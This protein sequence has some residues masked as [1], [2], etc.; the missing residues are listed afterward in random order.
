M[1]WLCPVVPHGYALELNLPGSLLHRQ[2]ELEC[3]DVVRLIRDKELRVVRRCSHQSAAV[4]SLKCLLDKTTGSQGL[5]TL[6]ALQV[7]WLLVCRRWPQVKSMTSPEA[8]HFLALGCRRVM[9]WLFDV[10]ESCHGG[11]E[12]AWQPRA[13]KCGMK[14]RPAD[15]RRKRDLRAE[16]NNKK[17]RNKRS[18]QTPSFVGNFKS[19]CFL[20]KLWDR[21]VSAVAEPQIKWEVRTGRFAYPFAGVKME[22][23]KE[24]IVVPLYMRIFLFAQNLILFQ[25]TWHCI[26]HCVW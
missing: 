12:L 5:I 26:Q 13:R 6:L 20:P 19:D 16:S 11:A 9:G 21:I 4:P 10:D 15:Q 24:T 23:S 7:Y 17:E 3:V 14:S 25:V 18:P 2:V 1:H 22:V 8:S